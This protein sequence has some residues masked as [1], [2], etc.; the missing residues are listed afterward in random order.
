M[1]RYARFIAVA[2][3]A[4]IGT[5]CA[6]DE[7]MGEALDNQPPD[8]RISSGPADGSVTSHKARF[9]WV[10]DDPDGDVRFYEY[11]IT[12]DDSG[13][14][15]PNAA[16]P[17]DKWHRVY[18]NDS[19]FNFTADVLFD[20]ASIDPG[21]LKPLEF[22]RAHTFVIRAVDDRGLR[23]LEPAHRSFTAKNLSPVVDVVQPSAPG[24]EEVDVSSVST[25]VWN[26]KDF[27]GSEQEEQAPDSVRSILVSVDSSF[28]SDWGAAIDYVRG[29]PSVAE[30]SRWLNYNAFDGSG[31]RWTTPSLDPGPYVFA[32]QVKD[33]AG[34]VSK[35]FD[36]DRNV[37]TIRV[38]GGEPPEGSLLLTLTCSGVDTFFITTR[39]TLIDVGTPTVTPVRCCM[40]PND[41]GGVMISGYRYGWDIADPDDAD[42]WEIDFTP[43]IGGTACSP[44]RTF[45][46]GTHS[47]HAEVI[48]AEGKR[49]RVTLIFDFG[50]PPR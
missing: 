47:F 33:D 25:F 49:I 44:S 32:V 26:G 24:A 30:W 18:R 12:D 17:A 21:V 48:D 45:S 10:G 31:T 34:A 9:Y 39:D 6:S 16:I 20:S 28:G 19:I 13:G 4:V 42:Q 14:F 36:L 29:N 38:V 50:S 3:A 41:T 1:P 2:F 40:T 43:F 35:G 46:F 8:V 23:S 11:A 5:N 7:F 22:R 27:I 15:D 37:R